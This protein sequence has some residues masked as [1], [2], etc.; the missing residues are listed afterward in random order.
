MYPW[1]ISNV[2]KQFLSSA[3]NFQ[4]IRYPSHSIILS[5]SFI[6][7]GLVATTFQNVTSH[8]IDTDIWGLSSQILNNVNKIV[9]YTKWCP[10]EAGNPSSWGPLPLRWFTPLR[11][12]SVDHQYFHPLWQIPD[13]QTAIHSCLFLF[14][15]STSLHD[16]GWWNW[17]CLVAKRLMFS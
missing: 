4:V 12:L 6:C 15:L 3:I 8:V 10:I 16:L 17:Y 9:K 1:Y 11:L 13:F 5:C 2:D 7:I 14:V